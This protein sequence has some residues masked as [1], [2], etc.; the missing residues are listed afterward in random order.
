M[1]A[2]LMQQAAAGAAKG[3]P[4]WSYVHNLL[5][6]NSASG[7]VITDLGSDNAPYAFQGT[8]AYSSAQGYAGGVGSAYLDGSTGN[9]ISAPTDTATVFGTADFTIEMFVYVLAASTSSLGFFDTLPLGGTGS[10][11]NSFIMYLNS[12]NQ[13]ALFSNFSQRANDAS[14]FP[15]NVWQHI[16]LTRKS[17]TFYLLRNGALVGSS[18]FALTDALGGRNIG[19]T[20]DGYTLANSTINAYVTQF[21]TTYGKARYTGAYAVPSIP[22]PTS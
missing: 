1:L 10:R 16:A 18:T 2:Q 12:S 15:L 13:L 5:A 17:G 6:L 8:A 21:R 20:A 3:D 22:Y 19:V 7:T 9:Y 14:S 4:Y 11:A